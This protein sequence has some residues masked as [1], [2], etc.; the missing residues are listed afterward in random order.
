MMPLFKKLFIILLLSASFLPFLVLAEGDA[1]VGLSVNPQKFELDVFP[2]EKFDYSID[3]KNLS[4]L[5]LP[6]K[7]RMA[8]FSALDDS[9]EMVFSEAESDSS[10]WFNIGKPDLILSSGESRKVDFKINIPEDA[11][12]GGY[13]NVMIFEPQMPSTYF[14]EG[15]PRAVPVIGV[16]FLISVKTLSI[17]SGKGDSKLQIVDFSIPKEER[18]VSLE[19]LASLFSQS[20]ASIEEASSPQ[21]LS[22]AEKTPSSFLVRI[23]NTDI[24][25][26]KSSGK[27]TIYDIFGRKLGEAAIDEKTILPGRI[28]SFKADFSLDTPEFLKWMPASVSSFF[29]NN[30]FIGRYQAK[31]EMTGESPVPGNGP[32]SAQKSFS[33][34][35]FAWKFWLPVLTALILFLI[36]RKRI[37]KALV[38]LIG[39]N[40]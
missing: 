35:V 39:R 28:R 29:V 5:A 36:L 38:V 7:V 2:G 17:D 40:P 32:A 30:F 8:D 13:Y 11:G 4:D 18:I 25:H 22:F 26:V 12:K 21:N 34:F 20:T 14:K 19:K 16:I 15:Q 24:Y 33:F 31:V 3:L 37:K 6:V 10:K 1:P 27:V 23:K 9:G